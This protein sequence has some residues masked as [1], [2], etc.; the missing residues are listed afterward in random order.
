[1]TGPTSPRANWLSKKTNNIKILGRTSAAI[2]VAA[3]LWASWRFVPSSM[4]AAAIIASL[5]VVFFSAL[6]F[7]HRGTFRRYII[8]ALWTGAII[9][10]IFCCLGLLAGSP[11]L[12]AWF[13]KTVFQQLGFEPPPGLANSTTSPTTAITTTFPI[14]TMTTTITG[15]TMTV[16]A[17]MTVVATTTATVTDCGF[18]HIL[19]STSSSSSPTTRDPSTFVTATVDSESGDLGTMRIGEGNEVVFNVV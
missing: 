4:I 19:S 12:L 13:G 18:Y 10:A 7:H 16:T 3:F 15:P 2:I 8:H 11:Q 1:M 6:D 9:V 5:C 17:T 14:A